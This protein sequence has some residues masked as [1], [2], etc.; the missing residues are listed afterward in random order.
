MNNK[1]KGISV[2]EIFKVIFRRVWWVVGV[3]LAFLLVFVLVI[4]FWYNRENRVY[5]A[6]YAIDFPGVENNVY[7]DGSRFKYNTVVSEDTLKA[8]VDSNEELSGIDVGAMTANGDINLSV[9]PIQEDESMS[10]TEQNNY[11]LTVNAKYFADNEQAVA[12]LRAVAGYP[13]EHAKQIAAAID[14]AAYLGT[15][16]SADSFETMINALASQ[17][18]YISSKYDEMIGI[19]SG[20]YMF[21]GRTLA[22]YR[23]EIEQIFD[24]SDQQKLYDILATEYYVLDAEEFS[25]NAQ[26]Q[27][28]AIEKQIAENQAKIDAL[29]EQRDA[30]DSYYQE[31]FNTQIANLTTENI[32][33]DLQVEDIYKSLAWIK[34]DTHDEDLKNFMSLLNGYRNELYAATQTFRAIYADYFDNACD[35]TPADKIAIEGGMNVVL[36]AVIGAIVGF[37]VVSIVICAIDFP[38]YLRARRGV[39]EDDSSDKV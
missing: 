8:I 35:V 19:L 22:G 28:A 11:V 13:V 31:A 20:E 25:A 36:A 18:D 15:F 33:L 3:T 30:A 38:A 37:V 1:E 10:G 5:T 4:Q 21:N 34:S 16:D 9:A 39:V 26:A 23:A 14:V 24:S 6:T 29:I 2:A 12:F 7:P 17:R 32:E 27:I